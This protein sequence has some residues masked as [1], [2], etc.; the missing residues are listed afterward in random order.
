MFVHH[1]GEEYYSFSGVTQ[2]ELDAAHEI[3]YNFFTEQKKKEQREKLTFRYVPTGYRE[4]IKNNYL[5]LAEV[6]LYERNILREIED[7][8]IFFYQN[9]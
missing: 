2:E 5:P 4:T 1:E 3:L 8:G 7:L 6:F 9:R